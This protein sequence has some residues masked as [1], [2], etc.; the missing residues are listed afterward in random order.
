MRLNTLAHVAAL[1]CASAALPAFAQSS[2]QIYGTVDV[3]VGVDERQ[4]AGPPT[5]TGAIV[6]VRGVHNGAM[7]T[8][9]WGLRGTEELGGGLKARFQLEGFFRADT[10]AQGRFGP[11]PAQ[12]LFFSRVAFVALGGGF[13]E[14]KL[15]NTP[16][17]TWLS[18]IQTNA[19]GSNSVFSPNFRTLYNGGTR[20]RSEAD[21]A[22]VNSVQYST[23][24]FGGVSANVALQAGENSGR[25]YSYNAN[26]VYRAGP[27]V[28][29]AAIQDVAGT[30][31]PDAAG[32]VDQQL[33]LIG[34]SYNLG[35]MR[36]F[37][38]YVDIDDDLNRTDDK[39]PSFGVQVPLAGGTIQAGA[40][41]DKLKPRSTAVPPTNQNVERTVVTLGYVYPMSKR[42]E[43]YTFVMQDKTTTKN[44]AG[45]ATLFNDK[46]NSYMAGIRH[47]F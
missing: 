30:Q 23:P 47:Q 31:P 38:Q 46:A 44:F 36:V 40:A 7:Q 27:V 18:L 34:A 14:V 17:P 21:T 2:V 11:A 24:T 10:G 4:P 45:T 16:N 42:T 13:G 3:A 19:L 41:R 35:F 43:L 28:L 22:L 12:D 26:V 8:S 29:T 6:R 39:V 25:R 1:A 32:N 20:G 15:G 33:T 37:A 5:W 9:Y